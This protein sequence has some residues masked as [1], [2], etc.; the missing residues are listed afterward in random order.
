VTVQ[1]V[2]H[3]VGQFWRHSS[4]RV[5]PAEI[6]RATEIL[7]PR[8]APFFFAL[9]LNDQRHGLDVLS[10][11]EADGAALPALLQ[12]AA[13]LHDMGKVDARFSVAERSLTVFLDRVSPAL[14]AAMLRLRPGF[15]RRFQTYRDHAG[16]GAARLRAVGATE[17]AAVVEEHHADHPELE[18]TRR[19]R[20]ADARN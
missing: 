19:L 6:A 1:P 3:R 14:L 17:L 4:A 11:V 15:R 2:L 9:P 20:R 8:L 10:T 18:I 16:V 7:G 5:S 12:Q 13:L